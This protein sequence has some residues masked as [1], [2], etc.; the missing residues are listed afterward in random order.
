MSNLVSLF[1]M[2]ILLLLNAFFVAGEFAV[3]SIR[4]EQIENGNKSFA[5]KYVLYALNHAST[6]LS[7]TQLGITLASTALGVI[8]EPAIAHF[9]MKPFLYLSISKN[10]AHIIAFIVA[11][12]LVVLL[13]VI[14]GEVIPKNLSVSMPERVIFLLAPPLIIFCK[15][16][17][18]VVIFLDSFS[19]RIIKMLNI[20]IKTASNHAYTIEEFT[21]IV[22]ES[23]AQGTFKDENNLVSTV[24]EFSSKL[25]KN[26]MVSMEN[27]C[28]IALPVT[29]IDVEKAVEKTGFSRFVITDNE[30]NL[31]SYIHL[32]DILFAEDDERD[33]P[34]DTWRLRLLDTVKAD[35]EIEDVLRIMQISGSHIAKVVENDKIIGVVF[36]EDIIEELVGEIKDIMQKEKK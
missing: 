36:L 29:P 15:I 7:C 8:A 32:K 24:L 26:V 18:P 11:L 34:L 2:I 10:T 22:Q 30:G 16:L 20:E 31:D 3:V 4:R 12:L 17:G 28:T 13:H 23:K 9:F 5:R 21:N 14:F 6:M 27:I 1:V 33:K 19:N 25:A 35:A